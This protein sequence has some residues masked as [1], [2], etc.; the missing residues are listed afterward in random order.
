MT[1]NVGGKNCNLEFAEKWGKKT[2]VPPNFARIGRDETKTGRSILKR[3]HSTRRAR[4]AR[5]E[6]GRKP[7]NCVFFVQMRLVFVRQREANFRKLWGGRN[8]ARMAPFGTKLRGNKDA[9][10]TD[11]LALSKRPRNTKLYDFFDLLF[12]FRLFFS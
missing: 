1:T 4:S 8:G 7:E 12:F 11:G 10:E 3:P 5:P 9:G 2:C 6:N